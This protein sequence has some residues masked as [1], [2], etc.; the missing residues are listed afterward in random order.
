MSGKF[1]VPSKEEIERNARAK[2]C[3]VESLLSNL[4][5]RFLINYNFHIF[6]HN[7]KIDTKQ[8][9]N[10]KNFRFW[11]NSIILRKKLVHN[12]TIQTYQSKIDT[13][14]PRANV[15][16]V[17]RNVEAISPNEICNYVFS[18]IPIDKKTQP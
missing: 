5:I 15:F 6:R 8:L 1:I 16:F 18:F 17:I 2:G 4:F 3:F 9:F 7:Y 14:Q 13:I 12:L 10:L 11:F